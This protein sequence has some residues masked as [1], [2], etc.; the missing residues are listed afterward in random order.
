[1]GL[2]WRWLSGKCATSAKTSKSQLSKKGGRVLAAVGTAR[3]EGCSWSPPSCVSP[4]SCPWST[5]VC[6]RHGRGHGKGQTT[7]PK[8]ARVG[9]SSLRLGAQPPPREP[10]GEVSSKEQARGPRVQAPHWSC[11][12]QLA[13]PAPGNPGQ[14]SP[15]VSLPVF[16]GSLLLEGCLGGL[17]GQGLACWCWSANRFFL[18]SRKSSKTAPAPSASS[19][20]AVPGTWQ[21]ATCCLVAASSLLCRGRTWCL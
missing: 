20:L 6:G 9:C 8:R 10:G 1:M 5:P 21:V 15:S 7:A 11:G 2:R 17:A 19:E 18:S 12:F 4:F 14:F 16:Q 13:D 3:G